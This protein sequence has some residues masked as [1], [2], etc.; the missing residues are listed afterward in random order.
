MEIWAS[1]CTMTHD[2][3][4]TTIARTPATTNSRFWVFFLCNE[5]GKCQLK[6]LV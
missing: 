2:V 6:P 4:G 3:T 1:A 5:Y